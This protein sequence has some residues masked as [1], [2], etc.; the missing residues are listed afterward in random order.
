MKAADEALMRLCVVAKRVFYAA[1]SMPRKA[2]T[3]SNV[4]GVLCEGDVCIDIRLEA[5]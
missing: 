1:V 4:S 5:S 3:V 2:Q